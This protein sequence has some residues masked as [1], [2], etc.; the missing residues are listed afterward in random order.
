METAKYVQHYR[1]PFKWGWYF[2]EAPG[3]PMSGLMSKREA[4]RIL[5]RNSGQ[6]GYGHYITYPA[7]AP[8]FKL[9]R[10]LGFPIRNLAIQ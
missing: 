6:Y 9:F 7:C 4:R 5:Q 2:V 1:N 8:R 10:R 3:E